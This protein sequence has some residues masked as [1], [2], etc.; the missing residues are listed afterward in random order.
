MMYE[1]GYGRESDVCLL[2]ERHYRSVSESYEAVGE[3]LTAV[4]N[5]PVELYA[6]DVKRAWV[7]LGTLS[8]ETASEAVVNEIFEKFCVGK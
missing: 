3:A 5:A 7:A 4:M 6:E 2:E 8:G 1:K